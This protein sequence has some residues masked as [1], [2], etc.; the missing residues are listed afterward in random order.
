MKKALIKKGLGG[1]QWYLY[2][3]EDTTV[4]PSDENYVERFDTAQEAIEYA[5]QILGLDTTEAEA[6]L[7]V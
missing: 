3:V 7:L 1:Q 5:R 6:T 4:M 2:A